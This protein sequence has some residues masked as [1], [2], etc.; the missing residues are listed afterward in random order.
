MNSTTTETF[1]R[2]P[3]STRLTERD[4]QAL[5]DRAKAED[6]KPTALL[7]AVLRQYL[8]DATKSENLS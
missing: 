5:R 8:T 7:R 6:M 4:I 3:F 2:S 1:S